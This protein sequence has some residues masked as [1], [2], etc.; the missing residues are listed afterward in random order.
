MV[1]ATSAQQPVVFE[2]RT[3]AHPA[4]TGPCSI[5]REDLETTSLERVVFHTFK[6]SDGSQGSHPYHDA[7]L[8][9]WI[10]TCSQNGVEAFCPLCK[11]MIDRTTGIFKDTLQSAWNTLKAQFNP[12]LKITGSFCAGAVLAYNAL[13]II[14]SVENWLIPKDTPP[15]PIINAIENHSQSLGF[16]TGWAFTQLSTQYLSAIY[17]LGAYEATKQTLNLLERKSS[18]IAAACGVTA[19][20]FI[21]PLFSLSSQDFFQRVEASQGLTAYFIQYAMIAFV[22][23]SLYKLAELF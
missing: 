9:Q 18:F 17:R 5:C 22:V 20:V 8:N 23:T 2:E 10:I 14:Q 16:L 3:T 12:C 21:F 13:E 6:A 15:L 7:C 4:T 11:Q 1:L 19:A